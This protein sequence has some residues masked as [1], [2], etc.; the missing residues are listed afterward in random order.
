MSSFSSPSS[1]RLGDVACPQVLLFS[2]RI[3]KKQISDRGSKEVRHLSFC[4]LEYK[5]VDARR[6]SINGL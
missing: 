2:K 5:G 1:G 6:V 4:S 3:R